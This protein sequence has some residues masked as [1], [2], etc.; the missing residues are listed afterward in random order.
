MYKYIVNP[1]T[2]RKV[3]Y[4][5]RLGKHIIKRYYN[6]IAGG[7]E[8]VPV[9]ESYSYINLKEL[10]GTD[11][12]SNLYNLLKTS[13]KSSSIAFLNSA[14]QLEKLVIKDKSKIELSIRDTTELVF[15]NPISGDLKKER[16]DDFIKT[17]L[18]LKWKGQF[19]SFYYDMG[20]L[21]FECNINENRDNE[22][23]KYY[24]IDYTSGKPNLVIDN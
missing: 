8:C 10:V 19:Y 14:F 16:L 22:I 2:N 5:S 24:E 20:F 6:Q 3:R 4:T 21:S 12:Y 13:G 1:V 15:E 7:S 11:Q 23:N 17:N 18:K 9:D